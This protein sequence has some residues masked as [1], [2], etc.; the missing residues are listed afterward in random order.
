[1][2]TSKSKSKTRLRQGFVGQ[3]EARDADG[4][5]EAGGGIAV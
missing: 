3:G 5:E 4:E 1:M 2:S